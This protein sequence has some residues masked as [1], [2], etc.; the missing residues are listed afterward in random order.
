MTRKGATATSRDRHLD[1]RGVGFVVIP[2]PLPHRKSW[3]YG[4]LSGLVLL[5]S[6]SRVPCQRVECPLCGI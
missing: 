4:A 3:P 1:R 2:L 5:R 6:R